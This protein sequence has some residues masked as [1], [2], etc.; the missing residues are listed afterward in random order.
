MG[1]SLVGT[2]VSLVGVVGSTCI[3]VRLSVAIREDE[4]LME[5][6]CLVPGG[7]DFVVASSLSLDLDGGGSGLG[8]S[9]LACLELSVVGVATTSTGF[10][11]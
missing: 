4:L 1:V 2:D 8:G 5:G 7:F 3:P 10:V 11:L 6:L 9:G